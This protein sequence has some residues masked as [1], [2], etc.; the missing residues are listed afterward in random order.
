VAKV[1]A[2]GILSRYAGDEMEVEGG[3]SVE[4]L[5]AS[6][7]IPSPL[8]GIVLVNGRQVEKSYVIGEEDEVKLIPLLG[9]G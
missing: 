3:K 6:L 1:K 7:G 4:E 2:V 5:L 9:G 8:V